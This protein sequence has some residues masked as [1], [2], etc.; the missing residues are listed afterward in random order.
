M[1]SVQNP[2]LVGLVVAVLVVITGELGFRVARHRGERIID[3]T[4]LGIIQ[5]AAFT[6]VALLL[7][8]SFS[9][10]LAR[11]D[12]RREV[13]VKEANVI[14]T[15]LLRVDLLDSTYRDPMHRYLAKYA[16]SRVDFARAGIDAAAQARAGRIS[17]AL[18]ERMW[19]TAMDAAQRDRR[20]TLTP[21]FIQALNNV[22]DVEGEQAAVLNAHIP[23]AVLFILLGIMLIAAGLLGFSL[24]KS[25]RK[26]YIPV[27]ML[28]VMLALESFT[29]LDLDRPQRG[30][31]RVDLTPLQQVQRSAAAAAPAAR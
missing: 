21:L 2:A 7:G 3:A 14:G 9:L 24:G 15:L 27:T 10:A 30:F 28:A 8:F 16:T 22:I 31:I 4:S 1:F 29:I 26:A 11:Y 23:D 17:S 18:Q 6:L 25:D 20:S 12:A 13:T 19:A 5:A